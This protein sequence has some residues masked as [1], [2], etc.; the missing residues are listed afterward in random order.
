[1]RVGENHIMRDFIIGIVLKIVSTL[2]ILVCWTCTAHAREK[3][4]AILE[5]K[6]AG[7]MVVGG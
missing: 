3:L 7:K 5:G 4:Y 6:P 1:M 2:E